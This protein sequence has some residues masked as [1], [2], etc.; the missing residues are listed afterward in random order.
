MDQDAL[1]DDCHEGELSNE[2][3]NDL[4]QANGSA[5]EVSQTD[6]KTTNE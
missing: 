3:A 4:E 5:C 6:E 2:V 1:D